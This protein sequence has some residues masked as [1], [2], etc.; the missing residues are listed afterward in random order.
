[1]LD[2]DAIAEADE[3][4]TPRRGAAQTRRMRHAMDVHSARNR[5]APDTGGVSSR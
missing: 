5:G 2:A 1:M 4:A 3:D